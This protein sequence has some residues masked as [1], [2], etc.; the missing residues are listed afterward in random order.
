M[1]SREL[2]RMVTRQPSRQF[3][4]RQHPGNHPGKND[5]FEDRQAFGISV[6]RKPGGTPQRNSL[7]AKAPEHDCGSRIGQQCIEG[8]GDRM[9][10][11]LCPARLCREGQCIRF[12]DPGALRVAYPHSCDSILDNRARSPRMASDG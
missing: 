4:V 2:P 8:L 6:F 10:P 3:A 12:P 11:G 1:Q 5:S 7:D 9:E